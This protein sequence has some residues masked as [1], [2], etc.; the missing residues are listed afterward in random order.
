M[1]KYNIVV[2]GYGE[3]LVNVAEYVIHVRCVCVCVCCGVNRNTPRAHTHTHTP[4]PELHPQ[5]HLP[6]FHHNNTL[7]YRILSFQQFITLANTTV[8]SLKMVY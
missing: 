2:C 3:M 7:L 8:N 6:T 4:N 1:I 5:P